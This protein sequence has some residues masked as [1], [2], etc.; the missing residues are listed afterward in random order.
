M[1]HELVHQEVVKLNAHIAENAKL[2]SDLRDVNHRL[3][4]QLDQMRLQA[5]GADGFTCTMCGHPNRRPLRGPR[6]ACQSCAMPQG[7]ERR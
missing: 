1:N 3:R 2:I 4:L 6:C 5:N 7:W